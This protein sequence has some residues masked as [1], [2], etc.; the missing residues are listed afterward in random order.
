[1]VIATGRLL[2]VMEVIV[3]TPAK[4]KGKGANNGKG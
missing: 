4:K 1:M 2:G 3:M